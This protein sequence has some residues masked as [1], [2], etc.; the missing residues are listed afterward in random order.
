MSSAS[1]RR[2]TVGTD[3]NNPYITL[4]VAPSELMPLI[5][6]TK[7]MERK[8]DYE[9]DVNGAMQQADRALELIRVITNRELGLAALIPDDLMESE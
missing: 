7:I 6:L 5:E 3:P 2:T 4:V 8:W 9:D 1:N